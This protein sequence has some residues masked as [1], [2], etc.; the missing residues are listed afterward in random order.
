MRSANLAAILLEETFEGYR[1]TTELAIAWV[2]SGSGG[3]ISLGSDPYAVGGQRQ[4]VLITIAGSTSS[5]GVRSVPSRA[6]GVWVPA[7]AVVQCGYTLSFRYRA[8]AG[9]DGAGIQATYAHSAFGGTVS[10]TITGDDAWHTVSG[11]ITDFAESSLAFGLA[12][13]ATSVGAAGTLRLDDFT[14]TRTSPIARGIDYTAAPCPLRWNGDGGF[15]ETLRYLTHVHTARDGSETREQL[16]VLPRWRVE[17]EVRAESAAGAARIDNWLWAN[18]GKAIAV[19]RWIDQ[20]TFD[21]LG[22]PTTIIELS[23]GTTT[24]RCYEA[25]QRIMLWDSPSRFEVLTVTLVDSG[26][27]QVS[28]APSLVWTAGKTKVV[29]LLTGWLDTTIT[30]NRPNSVLGIVPMAFDI[31]VAN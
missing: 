29:P 17:Y 13:S 18:H 3:T 4:H 30:L 2:A 21:G 28:V 5:V 27:L 22:A 31:Q 19:P 26:F 7:D 9:L 23:G 25:Q 14:I 11:P 20:L 6:M 8:S 10:E 1:D 24:D 12:V 15:R 16:R